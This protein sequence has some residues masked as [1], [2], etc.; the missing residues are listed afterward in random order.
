MSIQAAPQR[1]SYARFLDWA[2]GRML[3]WVDGQV[4]EMAPAATHHQQLVALLLSVL[5]IFVERHGLGE[6]LP[7]PYQMKLERSGREPDLLYVAQAHRDRI[8]TVYLDGPADLVVEIVSPESKRRDRVE[9]RAE[10]EAARVPEY[11]LVDP[12]NQTVT[13]CVIG[14]D[15]RYQ[16]TRPDARGR[17]RSRELP[18]MWIDPSWF[19]QDPL[20]P[21]LEILRELGVLD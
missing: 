21:A 10:Y 11:W 3:E 9:K 2:D 8:R 17:L 4:V 5:R 7:A 16:E 20:P 15:G 1:M 19:W 14:D 13:I 12:E 6:V 18:G